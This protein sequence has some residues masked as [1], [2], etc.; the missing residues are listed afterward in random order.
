MMDDL[1]FYLFYG[2]F[3][4]MP[5]LLLLILL[6]QQ[7]CRVWSKRCARKLDAIRDEVE[8]VKYSAESAITRY[9]SDYI[10]E[11]I[12]THVSDMVEKHIR[13]NSFLRDIREEDVEFVSPCEEPQI[14]PLKSFDIN[15]LPKMDPE[16]GEKCGA[17][18]LEAFGFEQSYSD[19]YIKRSDVN[20][21][22]MGIKRVALSLD[23]WSKL[24]SLGFVNETPVSV[25]AI[26]NNILAEHFS[27]Y[28][29]EIDEL[30]IIGD[31][32]KKYGY[33]RN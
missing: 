11:R 33:G 6:T 14:Q 1:Y 7:R 20:L 15:D 10:P 31:R 3:T 16:L 27:T 17:A 13:E 4:L 18:I 8:S 30:V 23:H 22:G 12:H 28:G 24:T 5:I 25:S 2:S 21:N 9:L 19:K 32:N 26:V 29:K